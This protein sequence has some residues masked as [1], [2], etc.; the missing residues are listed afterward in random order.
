MFNRDCWFYL[1]KKAIFVG[2]FL[3][4][5]Q[6]LA[7]QE[8][9]V[10]ESFV[11]TTESA[12]INTPHRSTWDVVELDPSFSSG[13]YLGMGQA[14]GDYNNDGWVDL[15]LT[16]GKLPNHLYQNNGDG[17]FAISEH[18]DDI[19]LKDVWTGGAVWAD[20][21]ND[22][23]KDLY[24]LAYGANTLFRNEGGRGFRDVTKEAGV[25][26]PLRSF[27]A[28]WGDY[29]NDGHLDLYVTNWACSPECQPS[30]PAKASDTLYKNNG[31]NN[32]WLLTYRLNWTE[33]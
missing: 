23:F 8:V 30:D 11:D 29:N 21:N 4:V 19:S 31:G 25:G 32:L 33:L 28:S 13:G 12:G 14:W 1:L 26:D 7:A 5:G 16:G 17:T 2:L 18:N 10:P 6:M 9:L 22:G 20:Y 3:L 27:T 15:F 24:V